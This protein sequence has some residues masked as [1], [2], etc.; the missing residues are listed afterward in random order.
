M[1]RIEFKGKLVIVTGASSGLGREIA[2]VLAYREGANLVVTARRRERLEELKAE[3]E[4]RSASRVYVVQVDLADPASA[5]VLFKEA[6]AI[7]D[8]FALISN[9]GVTYYGK[10]LDG[11]IQDY[12]QIVN[13]NFMSVVKSCMLFLPYFLD[14]GTGALLTVTSMAALSPVPYQAVYSASKHAT[15][16]FIEGL[17]QEYKGRGVVFSNFAPGGIATEMITKAGIDKK[18]PL[19]SPVNMDAG[20]VAMMAVR[21]F[22]KGKLC[23]VPGLTYKAANLLGRFF[24]RSVLGA[25]AERIFKP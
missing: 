6:T 19:D 2:R 8:V 4:S 10:T 23:A 13:V 1:K 12:E 3:I 16:A 14:R 24:P 25:V 22:K 20:K 11:R 7:G 15:Q 5:D 9:A 21:G 17:A 18:H